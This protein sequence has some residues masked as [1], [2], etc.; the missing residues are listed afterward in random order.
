MLFGLSIELC[1]LILVADQLKM[2]TVFDMIRRPPEP[3]V[4]HQRLYGV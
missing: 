3:I 4:V 2:F 1:L